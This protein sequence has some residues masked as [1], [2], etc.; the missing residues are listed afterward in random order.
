[1]AV[2]DKSMPVMQD[3]PLESEEKSQIVAMSNVTVKFSQNVI[4]FEIANNSD[5]AT[6]YLKI[7]GSVAT[8]ST[9]IPIYPKNYY[10]ADKIILKDTGISLISSEN[11]TDVRIIGHYL[12]TSETSGAI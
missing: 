5:T 11:N 1:M 6:I 4:G 10:S 3:A 2:Y 12:L 7:D 9:G 8:V